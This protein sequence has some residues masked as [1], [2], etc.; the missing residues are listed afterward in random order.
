[1]RSEH[2]KFLLL[3]FEAN[4]AHVAGMKIRLCT[5]ASFF[6][7]HGSVECHMKQIYERIMIKLFTG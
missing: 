2:F 7:G 4:T 3:W 5:S 6:H 1:M